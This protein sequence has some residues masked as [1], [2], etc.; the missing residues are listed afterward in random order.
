MMRT[1]SRREREMTASTCCDF[2]MV[3]PVEMRFLIS[4]NGAVECWS[5]VRSKTPLLQH[6]FTLHS[7][8]EDENDDEEEIARFILSK[9]PLQ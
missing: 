6:S 9:F 2:S 1:G 3:Q 7:E 8:N 5:N 4:R